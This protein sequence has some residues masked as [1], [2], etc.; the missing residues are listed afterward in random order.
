MI[1]VLVRLIIL[2]YIDSPDEEDRI[3][4]REGTRLQGT[5]G[6]IK[7]RKGF[8]LVPRYYSGIAGTLVPFIVND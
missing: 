4:T 5:F 8:Q 3:T 1:A 2:Q 6:I 7:S